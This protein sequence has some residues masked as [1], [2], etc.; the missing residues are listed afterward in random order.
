MTCHSYNGMTFCVPDLE[1][2]SRQNHEEPRW[3][4]TCNAITQ[5][6][7]VIY[8]PA[9][10]DTLSYPE[11]RIECSMCETQDSDLTED[12]YRDYIDPYE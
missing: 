5:F 11:A 6:E 8:H 4:Y 2:H 12:E 1:V 10:N 3:C 9:K 7:Y